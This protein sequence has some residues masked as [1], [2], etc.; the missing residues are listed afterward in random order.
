MLTRFLLSAAETERGPRRLT[1]R[2]AVTHVNHDIQPDRVGRDF[3]C[4]QVTLSDQVGRRPDRWHVPGRLHPGPRRATVR[5]AHIDLQISPGWAGLIAA[6]VLFGPNPLALPERPSSGALVRAGA[7]LHKR[8]DR[9][10]P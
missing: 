6:G 10:L 7:T 1:N 5:H 8:E 3:G 4:V 2:L 9:P